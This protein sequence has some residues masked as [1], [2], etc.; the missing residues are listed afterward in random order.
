MRLSWELGI[1][2]GSRAWTVNSEYARARSQRLVGG[3]KSVAE[4]P[5]LSQCA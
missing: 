5:H 1:L 4:L 3:S 2:G